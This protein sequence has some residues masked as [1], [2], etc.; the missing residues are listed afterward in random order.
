MLRDTFRRLLQPVV[1]A[2]ELALVISAFHFCLQGGDH[3]LDVLDAVVK[4]RHGGGGG[5]LAQ[6]LVVACLF[7][8]GVRGDFAEEVVHGVGEELQ[9][10]VE[11][12]KL[13]CRGRVGGWV[14]VFGVAGGVVILCEWR[15]LLTLWWWRRRLILILGW[16]RSA[17]G[18]V[19]GEAK[20]FDG[21]W[22]FGG[23]GR[24]AEVVVW[25]EGDLVAVEA[26]PI[27]DEHLEASTRAGF[28]RE[29]GWS[30]EV[31]VGIVAVAKGQSINVGIVAVI[32]GTVV[33]KPSYASRRA[34]VCVYDQSKSVEFPNRIDT[35]QTDGLLP[36]GHIP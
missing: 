10:V 35:A 14:G 30:T 16:R 4:I 12:G 20:G 1:D 33:Q 11:V 3:H 25:G 22:G 32:L 6:N 13:R 17:A 18:G 36:T 9:T 24:D 34:T 5:Q 31:P 26:G 7:R 27:V 2:I 19:G 29:L 8:G 15:L 23:G 28:Q 21:I